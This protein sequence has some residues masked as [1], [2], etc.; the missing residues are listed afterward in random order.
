MIKHYFSS[1]QH[2]DKFKMTSHM[3]QSFSAD[4]SNLS[5]MMRTQGNIIKWHVFD[6]YFRINLFLL[7]VFMRFN[8]SVFMFKFDQKTF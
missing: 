8:A 2:A 6:L 3:L 4:N 7:G 1:F 5:E